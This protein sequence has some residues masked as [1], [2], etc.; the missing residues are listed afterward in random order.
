MYKCPACGAGLTFDPKSQQLLCLSCRNKYDPEDVENMK[1]D[2][3]KEN[4]ELA[5]GSYEAVAYKCSHCG[6]EL[7]TTDET[8]TTFCSF[9]RVGTMLDR[10]VVIKRKPDYIIPFLITKEECE[11]I[12]VKRIKKALLAPKSMI[13]TQEV[14]KIRGIYMPYWIYTFERNGEV[15]TSGKKYSHRSGDYVYYDDYSLS[16]HVKAKVQG[17][18][19]DA[20]SSF[21]DRLSETIAPYSVSKKKIFSPAYLSGFYADNED[22]DKNVY[23]ED[24]EQVA[25][26]HISNKLGKDK[27]YSKYGAK[28]GV[29]ME[30]ANTELALFPVYYLATKN[31][32]GDRISYAVINGQTGKIAADIPIDFKKLALVALVLAIPIFV[33]LNFL[34]TFNMPTM[35]IISILFNI[36][37]LCLLIHQNKKITIRENEA[38]DKGLQHKIAIEKA[39]ANDEQQSSLDEKEKT[40]KK[41]KTKTISRTGQ[42]VIIILMFIFLPIMLEVGI[43]A[44]SIF[45][46][47]F[48]TSANLILLGVGI[49]ALISAITWMIIRKTK[50]PEKDTSIYKP[51]IG[52]M[53]TAALFCIRPA[54]DIY[55]YVTSFASIALS[56]IS[57]KNTVNKY[58]ILTSRKLPGLEKRGGDEN[59]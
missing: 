2:Q 22:L 47:I 8:I 25:E 31:R 43:V 9:C 20:T 53:L 39:T 5:K 57:F 30:E 24:C 37:S 45:T 38:D 17:I 49:I 14:N 33:L 27:V 52:L 6:A 41:N 3:A 46:A 26:N 7:I 10:K 59:A 44:F 34:F 48:P 28:P 36:V 32:T 23:S 16:T 50:H 4:A 1:L 40:D 21:W 42:L 55:Y 54:S 56:I 12:Y 13:D 15:N 29:K 19:H 58:N 11:Q 18:T 35:M 51:I